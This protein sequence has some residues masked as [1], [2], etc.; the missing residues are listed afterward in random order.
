MQGLLQN[1][2]ERVRNIVNV[3]DIVRNKVVLSKKGVEYT[4]LCPFHSEKTPSFTVNDKKRFYHC[5]GCGAHGDVIK[6]ESETSGLSYKD[7]AY[8]IAGKYAIEI[9]KFSKEEEREQLESDRISSHL[10]LASNYFVS[11]INPEI[12]AILNKRGISA[13]TIKR[14]NIGYTGNSGGLIQYFKDRHYRLEEIEASGLVVK[15]SDGRYGEFFH[16]R[17]TIPI[18]TAFGKIIGFGARS[19]GNELPKYLNS[20]ESPVFK[21]GESL[22]GE[23]TAYSSSHKKGYT[24]LVEGYFDVISLFQAGFQNVVASLGTAVTVF[25]L[26]KLWKIAEEII[27]CLDG[28]DA[29]NRASNKVL[30]LAAPLISG[31]KKLSFIIMPQSYDPDSLIMK[32]GKNYFNKLIEE[33]KSYSEYI[34]LTVTKNNKIATPEDRSELE[35]NLY[36]FAAKVL[37]PI[38][39]RNMNSF[40]AGELKKLYSGHGSKAKKYA[41]KILSKDLDELSH[42]DDIIIGYLLLNIENFEKDK[43]DSVLTLIYNDSSRKQ[44]L[45]YILEN[46][47]GE[48]D[49]FA[50]DFI[51]DIKKTG[52][53][54]EYEILS[55]ICKNSIPIHNDRFSLEEVM[56]YLKLKRYLVTLTSEFKRIT[57]SE[58][59]SDEKLSYY[60]SEIGNTK[61]KINFFNSKVA[62]DAR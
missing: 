33:R 36:G 19:L 49:N 35:R 48:N 51:E 54:V 60:L 21:K 30:D 1:F 15:R 5:F 57:S 55:S 17:I 9:P 45:D 29:G 26:E 38:L 44:L 11:K 6:F 27:V 34:Y 41:P 46:L 32:H 7:S 22:F 13:G 28:D 12:I 2:F 56:N 25:Q 24:I 20:S 31:K 61:E 40:F 58:E 16:N 37:D 3:S 43:I 18:Y 42:I 10:K 50:T 8:K 59:F 53:F 23:D 4:G 39:K 52:F 14:Y 47:S 62:L